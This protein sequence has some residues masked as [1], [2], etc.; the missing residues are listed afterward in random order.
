MSG[1]PGFNPFAL[2]VVRESRRMSQAALADN[3]GFTQ[4]FVSQVEKGL[5]TPKPQ[6]IVEMARALDCAPALLCAPLGEDQPVTIFRK[7]S[8]IALREVRAVRARV[9]LHQYRTRLL[10]RHGGNPRLSLRLADTMREKI[11]ARQAAGR[12]RKH[13]KVPGGPI[14]NLTELAERNGVLVMPAV[15]PQGVDG[16]SVYDP[17]VSLP[18]IIFLEAGVPG[19]RWRLSLAHELGHL[20]LHHHLDTLPD[21]KRAEHEAFEFASEFLCPDKEIRGYLHQLNM[22]RLAALK[23]HWKVSMA[24][25]LMAAQKAGRISSSNARWLWIQLRSGGTE[26]PVMV[27]SEYPA[28]IKTI[29]ANHLQATGDSIV[30]LSRKL[31]YR[32]P[33]DFR[34]D[35]G[36]STRLRAI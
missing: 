25:L 5:R 10:L 12:L 27:D 19:D 32:Q 17:L 11:S 15:L 35:Y 16:V 14:Q 29:V 28:L 20:V 31:H 7:R 33:A 22:H 23:V 18:P 2:V 34:E 3:I 6:V 4:P 30:T 24:S 9:A 26:E 1:D 8:R 36:L 21:P 13:W